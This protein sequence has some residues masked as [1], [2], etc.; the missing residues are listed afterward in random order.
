MAGTVGD[1]DAQELK[2]G[3]IDFYGLSRVSAAQVREALTVREG[4]TVLLEGDE[5][6]AF[7]KAS[8]DRLAALPE[9]AAAHL[10]LVC[11]DE[12]RAIVYVGIEERGATPMKLR[13]APQGTALLAADIVQAGEE[14]AKAS[15]A[16]VQGGDAAEDRSQGH[17]LDSDPA[18]RAIQERFVGFAKRD[19]VSIRLVLRSSSD[20]NQRALAAQVLGYAP[21]K[22]AVVEDLVNAM[23]DPS[24]AVRNNAMRALLVFADAAP[25]AGGAPIARIPA[26]PFVEFLNSPVWTDRNKAAGALLALSARPDPKL[27]ATL[28]QGALG[29]LAEMARWK[30]EGHAQAAF[31]IL[32]RIA[33]YP[34]AAAHDLWMRGQ[35]EVVI[36]AAV[37]GRPPQ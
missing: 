18:A 21:H 29:P 13:A 4:D 26:E 37:T 14:Y 31:T 12:G 32:G 10:S 19:L 8:E 1:V 27:L 23:R 6:P 16:A 15:L 7:M 3:I 17:A 9:V 2:I 30:S 20:E 35:R 28:R 33:G 24:E 34:D 11:C 5:R 36:E 22:Q 25:G